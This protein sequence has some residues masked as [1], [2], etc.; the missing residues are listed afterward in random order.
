MSPALLE[1]K[2]LDQVYTNIPGAYTAIPLPH[3]GQSDHLSLFML[4]KYT[5]LIKRVKPAVR[6]VKVW[7]EGAIS[8]LQQQFQDTDWN[9]F[10]SQAT[11][12]SHTDM[13]SYTSSVLDHINTCIDNVT[14]VKHVKCFPNQ[15]PW[16]NSEVRLL[17]KARDAAFKSG[18]AEDYN[19][20]RSNLKRGIRKA[21][22]TFKRHIEEHFHNSDPR[23]MWKGIQ[24][25][26]DYKPTAQPTSSAFQPNE[27]N[28]FFA[29]FDQS[30]GHFTPT[31]DSATAYS[32]LSISTTDVYSVFSR[33]DARKAAGPD[34]ILGRVLRACAGQL[35]QV[36]TDIFNLS[37]AQAMVPTCLKTTTI[38]PVPKHSAAKCLNDFR[39]VALTPL[40]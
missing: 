39:P 6:T 1:D 36:F 24:S 23:R 17:L 31:T 13:D 11:L 15:K 33:V 18:S 12:D 20:A 26:T 10:A 38:I 2:T 8:S 4:P 21:K 22:L 37:L 35:A 7:P 14:T 19:R 30:T 5:P 32:P 29:R 40:L 25:I 27:L 28:H 34:G 16:M 9:M 3:L